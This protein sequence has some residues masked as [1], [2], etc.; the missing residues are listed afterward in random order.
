M[1]E[2]TLSIIKKFLDFEKV[3]TND[4]SVCCHHLFCIYSEITLQKLL[5]NQDKVIP[6][7]N[8]LSQK[9]WLQCDAIMISLAIKDRLKVKLA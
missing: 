2:E 6:I 8:C 9:M 4:L 3:K 5:K 1:N 7:L